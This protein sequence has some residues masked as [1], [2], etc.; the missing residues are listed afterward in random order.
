MGDELSAII[1]GIGIN[2]APGSIP[3]ADL[4]RYPAICVENAIGHPHDRFQLFH[5]V[6]AA[7][8]YWRTKIMTPEFIQKWEEN[9]AYQGEIV[10]IVSPG[11]QENCEKTI[12]EGNIIGLATDGALKILTNSGEI[13]TIQ[14]GELHL[15]P[16]DGT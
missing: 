15:R 9:L 8:L 11:G 6:L 1:L 13:V 7:I 16:L 2:I 14:S 3:P 12:Y 5:D 4:L 10:Q